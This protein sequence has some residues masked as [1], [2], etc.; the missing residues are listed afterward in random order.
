M[1]PW[2]VFFKQPPQD[3]SSTL[4]HLTISVSETL[5]IP[6]LTFFILV[7][8]TRLRH[9]HADWSRGSIR[10]LEEHSE[11][12]VIIVCGKLPEQVRA[13]LVGGHAHRHH[14][15]TPH[16][17]HAVCVLPDFLLEVLY[18]RPCPHGGSSYDW[19]GVCC[20]QRTGEVLQSVINIYNKI[21]SCRFPINKKISQ[22][23]FLWSHFPTSIHR[24]DEKL[25]Q[26]TGHLCCQFMRVTKGNKRAHMSTCDQWQ[27]S[28]FCIRNFPSIF[29]QNMTL[30][31]RGQSKW[32]NWAQ[33][34]CFGIRPRPCSLLVWVLTLLYTKCVVGWLSCNTC[35]CSSPSCPPGHINKDTADKN[36]V[37]ELV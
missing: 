37:S 28:C 34:V 7:F 24:L 26:L 1:P 21:C 15:A 9:V 22:S 13:L 30:R 6:I 18:L 19:R 31:V 35:S 29:P 3:D 23:Y 4:P 32:N 2:P 36:Q 11:P 8:I 33:D 27:K 25:P 14:L 17:D 5:P 16:C 20:D 10:P 12:D